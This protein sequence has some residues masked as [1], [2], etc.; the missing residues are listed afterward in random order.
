MRPVGPAPAMT[1]S[2]ATGDLLY[3]TRDAA[4]PRPAA[5]PERGD[6]PCSAVRADGQQRVFLAGEIV[7]ERAGGHARSG[8]DVLNP[9]VLIAAFDGQPP[10]RLPQRRPGRQLLALPQPYPFPRHEG[11]RYRN[12]PISAIFRIHANFS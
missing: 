11:Q 4:R 6:D 12:M 8:C 10:G 1:T 5:G 9:G 2:A 7:I 3:V